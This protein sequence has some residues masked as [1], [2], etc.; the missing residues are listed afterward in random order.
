MTA[1]LSAAKRALID[2]AWRKGLGLFRAA[3]LIGVSETTISR[4]YRLLSAM[5]IPRGKSGDLD[6]DV[7]LATIEI[8]PEVIADRDRRA[9][10]VHPDIVGRLCG[11]PLPGCSALERRG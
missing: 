1:P 11:D 6:V 10:L 9:A 3:S 8:P 4:R 5:G 7:E 2:E